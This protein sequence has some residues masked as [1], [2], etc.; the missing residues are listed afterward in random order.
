MISDLWFDYSLSI[1]LKTG[2][3]C[4]HHVNFFSHGLV[5]QQ[6]LASSAL[7][8]NETHKHSQAY[9]CTRTHTHT[10]VGMHTGTQYTLKHTH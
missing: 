9:A 4:L 5:V 10:S 7:L 8:E 1:L 3:I 2:C 6:T